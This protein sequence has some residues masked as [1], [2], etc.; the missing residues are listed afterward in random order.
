MTVADEL[1][2][3]PGIIDMRTFGRDLRALR[4][5]RGFDLGASFTKML[6]ATYGVEVSDRTLYAIE[7][8][9]QMPRL[10]FFIA[11]SCAL[12]AERGYFADAIRADCREQFD[13]RG[14]L[15]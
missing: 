9:E 7:R 12:R 13:G 2:E 14:G 15:P 3:G 1:P 5:R 10:D 4:A 6:A 11:V 8:G